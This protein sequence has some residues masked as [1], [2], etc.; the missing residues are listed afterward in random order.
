MPLEARDWKG[1]YHFLHRQR[2]AEEQAIDT[3]VSLLRNLIIDSLSRFRQLIDEDHK[4]DEALDRQLQ[5]L[6]FVVRNQPLETVQAHIQTTVQSISELL[7]EKH[8]SQD[9]QLEQMRLQIQAAREEIL[10]MR[11][12]MEEDSL[13]GTHNRRA[14]DKAIARFTDYATFVK[15]DLA[16]LII[17]V[18][19]LK[20][21]NDVKGHQ[22]GDAMLRAAGQTLIR[23]FPRKDDFV[24]R[25]GGDEFCVIL[26]RTDRNTAIRLAQRCNEFFRALEIPWQDDTILCTVSIGGAS[27]HASESIESCLARADQ[28]LYKVKQAGRDDW[29]YAD[30]LCAP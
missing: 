29:A 2:L 25:Y 11:R 19:H 21:V 10:N 14:L 13:T 6:R 17:D 16:V 12:E 23:A 9:R 15:E 3:S 22:A 4:L 5:S 28:A 27:Y 24:A 7:D 20:A 26:S 1:L 8:R 30:D 18:D